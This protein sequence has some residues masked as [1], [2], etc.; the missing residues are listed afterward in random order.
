MDRNLFKI[1]KFTRYFA[2]IVIG[3]SLFTACG[4]SS[5]TAQLNKDETPIVSVYGNTLYQ[6]DLDAVLSEGLSSEDSAKVADAYIQKWVN[7]ELV[8]EKAKQN[9]A[10][11]NKINELVED[12]RQTLT[13]YTYQEQLLKEVLSKKISETELKKYYDENPDNFK[14]EFCIIKGMFLKVPLSS[15]EL[16]NIRKWYQSNSPESKEKIEKASLQNAVI[17]DYFYNK[18]VNIEEVTVNMPYT[19]SDPIQFVK[20][21]KNFETSDS[22]YTYLLHIEQYALPGAVAP[23]EFAKP[24]INDILVNKYKEE[25]M[26]QF[27]EDLY[28]DAIED[29][30]I[31][32]Y[33]K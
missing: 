13:T 1:N 29:K 32:Y 8:Y 2:E 31:K 22:T 24:Q 17:Y 7:E 28:K 20:S 11:I 5:K 23:Y 10:D 25:F 26:K 18:W 33:N 21:Y 15:P 4:D 12:Y 27:E 14:L 9:I 16:S 6:K 30:N 19:I 3:L